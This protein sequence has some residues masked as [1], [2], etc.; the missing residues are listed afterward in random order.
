M[1][2]RAAIP[3]QVSG[4]TR[5]PFRHN[6]AQVYR[7]GPRSYLAISDE[8]VRGSLSCADV[9]PAYASPHVGGMQGEAVPVVWS[10]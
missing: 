5:S 3:L 4:L 10:V 6:R 2:N 7:A 8:P 1:T 9:I